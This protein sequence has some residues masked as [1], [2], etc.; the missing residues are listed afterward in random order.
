MDDT[1]LTS[2][3]A[4]HDSDLARARPALI[5]AAAS[6]VLYGLMFQI[7]EEWESTLAGDGAVEARWLASFG[8][9]ASSLG[10]L[11]ATTTDQEVGRLLL[12]NGH[13]GAADRRALDARGVT[14]GWWPGVETE[15]RWKMAAA[16]AGERGVSE[17]VT[18]LLSAGRPDLVE[19]LYHEAHTR[20]IQI[21]V[22]AEYLGR[23]RRGEPDGAIRRD[24]E[25]RWL[26]RLDAHERDAVS[27]AMLCEEGM[28]TREVLELMCEGTLVDAAWYR[29]RHQWCADEDLDVVA[30][31]PWAAVLGAD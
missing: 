7:P 11:A 10:N 26:S 25:V 1:T 9:S 20:E 31:S 2:L 6:G 22:S 28:L 18:S 19:A 5:E 4:V 30:N 21:T 16:A 24:E 17:V 3:L 13:L 29:A 12:A 27:D 8:R 23:R 14:E 15:L